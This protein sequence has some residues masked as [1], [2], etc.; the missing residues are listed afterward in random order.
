MSEPSPQ[1][2]T[3]G[4]GQVS[5]VDLAVLATTSAARVVGG[6]ARQAGRLLRPGVRL[7][8]R[9]PL[10][11]AALHP[12]RWLESMNAVGAARRDAL[13][14]RLTALLDALVPVVVE[15]VV[16]RARLTDL[17]IEHLDL[18]RIVATVD[19][20]AAIER[21]DVGRVVDRVDVAPVVD[22]VDLDAVVGR[23]D[24]DAVVGR[25]DLDAILERLDLTG[26][27]LRRVD[28]DAVITAVLE[29]LDLVGLAADV[30]EGVDL[31][32]IIREST[33]TMASDTVRGVRMQ[34]IAADEAVGRAVDRLL[35]R[36]SG[37][38]PRTPWAD[39]TGDE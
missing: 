33:G 34:G 2:G 21:V 32:E 23:V 1:T 36:R 26:I 6:T 18:E 38:S 22:R 27:V 31:P 10:L 37:R 24:L 5:A 11:P 28:L 35:L 7:A 29:R 25:V 19:L 13:H 9:P 3:A 39:E 12:Q 30:I 15:E 16:R 8:L 20:D 4:P 17:V 14:R